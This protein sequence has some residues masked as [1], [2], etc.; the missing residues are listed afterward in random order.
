MG[1]MSDPIPTVRYAALHDEQ[2]WNRWYERPNLRALLPPLR[3]ATVLDVACGSGGSCAW[4]LDQGADVIGVDPGD[5]MIEA[6]QRRVGDRARLLVHDLAMP[7][8][9][10]EPAS[11]DLVHSSLTL[12]YLEDLRSFLRELHRL[13]RPGGALVA[14]THH[15]V[16]SQRA[17]DPGNY[18]RAGAVHQRWRLR[19]ASRLRWLAERLVLETAAAWKTQRL[20][21]LRALATK[22]LPVRYQRRTFSMLANALSDAGFAIDRVGEPLPSRE[23]CERYGRPARELRRRPGLLF[24]RARRLP[25]G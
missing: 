8:G 15:P 22:R 1:A 11:V 14:S 19:G 5:R 13:L 25:A 4:L 23:L 12:H 17:L 7:L 3:G 18:F 20:P 10:L 2:P 6:A 16:T 9:Q 24:L 21:G